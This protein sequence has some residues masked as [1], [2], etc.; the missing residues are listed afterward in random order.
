MPSAALLPAWS[1]TDRRT[2]SIGRGETAATSDGGGSTADDGTGAA[3]VPKRW[4]S[5]IVIFRKGVS[6]CGTESLTIWSGRTW[7][8][9]NCSSTLLKGS[10]TSR[11]SVASTSHWKKSGACWKIERRDT[12][13][14]PLAIPRSSSDA[15]I[16]TRCSGSTGAVLS[17]PAGR[18]GTRSISCSAI[19]RSAAAESSVD[20]FF[21]SPAMEPL[22]PNEILR[23][24]T[25]A[26][27]EADFRA[28]RPRK[29]LASRP[30]RRRVRR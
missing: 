20:A 14:R 17:N 1:G 18:C 21:D 8:A 16:R 10:T 13:G 22:P 5:S 4:P 6:T 26:W 9:V 23:G 25:R 24:G 30:L 7:K 15:L 28:A 19:V 11:L 29:S 2:G 3:G 12:V 27:P